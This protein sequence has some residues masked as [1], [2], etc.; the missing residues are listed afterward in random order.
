[1]TTI[2]LTPSETL[3]L[4]RLAVDGGE[5]W[6]KDVRPELKRDSRD[7]LAAAGLIEASKRRNPEGRGAPIHLTLADAGWAWIAANLDADLTSRSPAAAGILARLLRALKR[8]MD[9][10]DVPL[11]DLLAPAPRSAPAP[12]AA[13]DSAPS[14]DGD[15]AAR[16]A[17]AY[18]AISGGQPNVRVRL[19]DL[20]RRLEDVPREALDRELMDIQVRGEAALYRLND[21]REINDEDR[22]A[23]FRTPT[24]EERYIIYMGGRGS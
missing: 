1:M 9:R 17:S 7:R 23:V 8:Y 20:R 13:A 5:A 14:S 10:A 12:A 6:S 16:V 15:I 11:A 19:A 21:P 18:F 24:G 3:A 2:T 4:W 22:E